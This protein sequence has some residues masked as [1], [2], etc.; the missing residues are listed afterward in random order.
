M[1]TLT[2]RTAIVG[3]ALVLAGI[4]SASPARGDDY[5]QK[6]VLTFS[7]PVEIGGYRLPAGTYIFQIADSLSDRHI[8]RISNH[9]GTE[10][11]GLVMA[12]ANYRLEATDR[13][14]ITFNEVPAGSPETVRAWFYPGRSAGHEFVYP[15]R[16]AVEL[17]VASKVVVP[18]IAVDSQDPDLRTVPIV[19]VTPDRTEVPVASVIQTTPMPGQTPLLERTVASASTGTGTSAS[20]G[21][22][23]QLPQTASSIPLIAF[24]GIASLG[25][26]ALLSGRQYLRRRHPVPVPV[27]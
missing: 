4:V 5:D 9:D 11:I 14:V 6:T 26:A 22:G 10:Q 3:M 21:T 7:Q 20:I 25:M 8:V 23:G 12:I 2:L 13:T 16:R 27:P 17:A 19:A 1:E 18:A 24:L 15:K